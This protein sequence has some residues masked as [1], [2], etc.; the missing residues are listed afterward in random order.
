VLPSAYLTPPRAGR[1]FDIPPFRGRLTLVGASPFELDVILHA[2]D[3]AHRDAA[4]S[5]LVAR[6]SR[7]LLAVA[8]SFGGGRDEAMDRYAYILEKLYENDCHRL[9]VFQAEGRA[10]FSTWLTVAARR[11][12]LDHYRSRYGRSRPT[13]DPDKT[14]TLRG[15]RRRLADSLGAQLDVDLLPDAREASADHGMIRRE[16]ATRLATELEK[17]SAQDRL[18]LALRFEDDLPASKIAGLIGMPTPFHVHRRL[19]AVLGRLRSGLV[20]HGID[21]ST[22]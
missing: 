9:R 21:G 8:R 14:S 2:P 10:T 11:L 1:T 13:R 5:E 17:L 4:W 20:S 16:R 7:L 15:V 22:G 3:P 12:C 6:H 19:K 18:L